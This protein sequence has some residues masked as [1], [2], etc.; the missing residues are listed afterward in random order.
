M[1]KTLV[2]AEKPSVGQDLARALPGENV[3]EIAGGHD[4]PDWREMWKRFLE[5]DSLR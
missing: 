1:P 2:I 3:H 4:W 5:T